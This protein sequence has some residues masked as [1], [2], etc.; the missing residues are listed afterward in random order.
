MAA[1]TQRKLIIIL[2]I[3][4]L[5]VV[6]VSS[7]VLFMLPEEGSQPIPSS[8]TPQNG[9]STGFNTRVLQRS[10]Y[11]LLNTTLIQNGFLPVRPPATT[12]KANPFL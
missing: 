7:L 5:A 12:G 8:P 3:I 10:G 4:L 9:I 6:V 11:T 1:P 2:G